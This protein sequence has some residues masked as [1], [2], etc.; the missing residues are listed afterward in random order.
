MRSATAILIIILLY[1]CDTALND[2][3]VDDKV[4]FKFYGGEYIEEGLDVVQAA[5]NGYIIVGTTSSASSG[6]NKDI[7]IVKT[8]IRGH[9]QWIKTIGGDGDDIAR[10]I[11]KLADGTFLIIGDI[12]VFEDEFPKKEMVLIRIDALGNELWRK[13]YGHNKNA[14]SYDVEG[15]DVAINENGNFLVVGNV[16]FNALDSEILFFVTD[17]NGMQIGA[18]TLIGQ[19]NTLE[20]A[21]SV[22]PDPS[23]RYL[24]YICGST[25]YSESQGQEGYNQFVINVNK[26]GS[27]P[28]PNIIGGANDEFGEMMVLSG[29]NKLLLLGSEMKGTSSKIQ[30]RKLNLNL[31]TE[32]VVYPDMDGM[33]NLTGKAISKTTDGYLVV[34]EWKISGIDS[35]IV[36]FKVDDSGK[37]LWG[38]NIRMFGGEFQDKANAVITDKQ[39]NIL[40]T[41]Q[42]AFTALGSN[43]KMSLIKTRNDGELKP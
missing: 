17:A 3:A 34:A 12:T 37:T 22:L 35:R 14:T 23:G 16:S 10:K 4:F 11:K 39:G 36:L 24:A 1:A 5:D 25:N 43:A 29:D 28:F 32:W 6:F 33:E 30:L 27:V 38:K 18:P 15:I 40:I 31:D 42:T 20:E 8:D 9:T 21:K 7:L 26:D 41:G 19:E 2:I 13:T